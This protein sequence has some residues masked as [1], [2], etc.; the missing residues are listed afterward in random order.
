MHILSTNEIHELNDM[1]SQQA[2]ALYD[3]EAF[4]WTSTLL[5]ANGTL[6]RQLDPQKKVG[7]RHWPSLTRLES[8]PNVMPIAA[9]WSATAMSALEI[10]KALNF[11]QR[12]V[13]SFYNAANSLGLI[14]QDPEKLINKQPVPRMK[15]AP[16][17]LFS[18]LLKRLV[19]G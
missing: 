14:E 1:I 11:P 4:V 7:L 15:D 18:R 16:R 17:G 10:S 19:G 3:M 12:Y 9:Q 2:S 5:S 13:F 6:P 8:F